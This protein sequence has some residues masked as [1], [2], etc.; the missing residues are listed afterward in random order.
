MASLYSGNRSITQWVYSFLNDFHVER[1][2]FERSVEYL[3]GETAMSIDLLKRGLLERGLEHNLS[4]VDP[5]V[6]LIRSFAKI[7]SIY[8]YNNYAV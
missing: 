6:D 3:P 8:V 1:N 5:I 7:R 2:S 4:D